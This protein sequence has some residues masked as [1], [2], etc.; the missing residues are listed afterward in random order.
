[1]RSLRKCSQILHKE[2]STRVLTVLKIS[3]ILHIE[4]RKRKD[5]EKIFN[6]D[7][8]GKRHFGFSRK[9]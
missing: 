7:C 2:I 4:Q 8:S 9:C 6:S 5:L 3:V 1:M